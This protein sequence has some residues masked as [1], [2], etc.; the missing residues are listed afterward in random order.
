MEK[1]ENDINLTNNEVKDILG[2]PPKWIL[3]WGNLLLLLIMI[4]LLSGSFFIRHPEMIA[5]SIEIIP[6]KK[7]VKISLP[8]NAILD[9]VFIKDGALVAKG[10]N[11]LK[12][13]AAG[14]MYS[15]LS[16]ETGIVSFEQIVS[17]SMVIGQ[18]SIVMSIDPSDQGYVGKGVFPGTAIAAINPGQLLEINVNNYPKEDFGSLRATIVNKPTQDNDQTLVNIKLNNNRTITNYG[19]IVPIRSP[20]KGTGYIM[21]S[22]KTLIQWL[23][24]K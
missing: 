5:G 11:L 4:I 24:S 21:I 8:Q 3:R 19:K 22:N 6:V 10:D 1:I 18:D 15:V 20:M 17:K 7:E 16:A 2:T 23:L 9:T 13:T 14:K 12:Y